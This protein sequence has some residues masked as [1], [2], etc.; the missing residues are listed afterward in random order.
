MLWRSVSLT[1]LFPF[2][3]RSAFLLLLILTCYLPSPLLDWD[4]IFAD[5]EREANPTNF[6]FVPSPFPSPVSPSSLFLSRRHLLTSPFL[7]RPQTSPD[8]SRLEASSGCCRRRRRAARSGRQRRRRL[9]RGRGR[10]GRGRDE[11]GRDGGVVVA[12]FLGVFS[13]SI[14]L[15]STVYLEDEYRRKRKRKKSR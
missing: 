5:D 4:M 3:L 13:A 7:S 9:G 10:G 15:V 8:G 1:S 14:D 6:K 11:G 12:L 2:V